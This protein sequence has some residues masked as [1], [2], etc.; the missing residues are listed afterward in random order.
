LPCADPR[1]EK[2]GE[3][4]GLLEKCLLKS[5]AT[6]VVNFMLEKLNATVHTEQN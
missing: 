6:A 4:I 5:N 1:D 3:Q 2:N